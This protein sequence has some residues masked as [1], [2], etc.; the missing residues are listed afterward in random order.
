[1]KL[2]LRN[3]KKGFATNSSSYHSTTVLSEEEYD[4]WTNGEIQVEIGYGDEIS[5]EEW[6]DQEEL[7]VDITHYTTPGGEK[8]VIICEHGSNY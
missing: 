3:I 7:E 2:Y 5:Y 8:I 6:Q 1:M 4:K